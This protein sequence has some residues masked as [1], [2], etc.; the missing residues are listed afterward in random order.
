MNRLGWA[1]GGLILAGCSGGESLEPPELLLG[2][3]ECVECRMIVSDDRFAAAWVTR[4]P[5]GRLEKSVFDDLGCLLIYRQQR[6]GSENL[7]EYV[8]DF[9]TRAWLDLAT[10]HL[11][12]SEKLHSPM[13]FGIAAFETAERADASL[14]RREGE[15]VDIATIRADPRPFLPE[16]N[17]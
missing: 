5:N 6:P 10:A 3:D 2:V 12:R 11:I 8:K 9:E 13:A 15:R 1:L 4:D 16:A 7:G 17:H 14:G